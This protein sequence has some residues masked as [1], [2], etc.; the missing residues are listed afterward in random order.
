M[1]CGRSCLELYSS[2]TSCR[3]RL[4]PKERTWLRGPVYVTTN[5]CETFVTGPYQSSLVPRVDWRRVFSLIPTSS[6][7][8]K[9]FYSGTQIH[10]TRVPSQDEPQK[11]QSNLMPLRPQRY[12]NN[13]RESR[14]K[15]RRTQRRENLKQEV[16]SRKR[17]AF[18]V[19]YVFHLSG[20]FS[21]S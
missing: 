6:L 4:V 2:P 8:R 12:Q 7:V 1:T 14:N 16:V 18:R 3:N 11:V 17:Q 15:K 19:L 5:V 13:L 20:F 21:A 9:V 10:L